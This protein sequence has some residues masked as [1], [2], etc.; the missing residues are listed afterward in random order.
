MKRFYISDHHFAHKNIIKYCHRPFETVHDMDRFMIEKWN[1][2]VG[3]DDMVIHGGD[4]ALAAKEY[5]SHLWFDILNGE[6]LLVKGNHDGSVRWLEEM[7]VRVSKYFYSPDDDV[8]VAHKPTS[9][10]IQN[11]DGLTVLYG[12]IHDKVLP[13]P[14]PNSMNIS[15]E[16][17]DYTPKTIEQIREALR[18]K[19]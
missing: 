2:V 3:K 8:L 7:G 5:Y 11:T 13:N 16:N 15:V 1:S 4:F 10:F 12:H 19:Q 14:P 18:N 9:P 17:M 6:K